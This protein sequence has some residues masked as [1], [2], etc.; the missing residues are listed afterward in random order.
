MHFPKDEHVLHFWC[1]FLVVHYFALCTL[2]G[3]S[4]FESCV[5]HIYM[6]RVHVLIESCWVGLRR[7][8]VRDVTITTIGTP[9]I[10]NSRN[11]GIPV[12]L[13]ILCK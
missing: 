5:T 9:G 11:S 8:H 7:E 13:H 10:W 1:F 2:E 4:E 6:G 3:S 12:S